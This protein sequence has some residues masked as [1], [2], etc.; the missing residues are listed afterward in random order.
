MKIA[1]LGYGTIGSGV[2]EVLK[3]N[4]DVV[5]MNAGE[6]VEVKYVLDLRDFPGDPVENI[7]THDYE[8]IQ[9][10]EEV[11]LIVETMGGVHPAYEFVKA[12]LEKGRSVCSSNKEL[13]AVYGAE[14]IQIAKAH[15]TNFFF[16]ASVGGGIPI[17]RP[18][19][20]CITA[21]KIERINGILNGTT[22]FILTKMAEDGED[23]DVAL[24]TAQDLG[25][26]EK[27]P[28]ADVEGYDACRKIAI[29]ASLACKKQVNYEDIYTEGITKITATDFLYAK[30]MG[31]AIKIFGTAVMK[32]GKVYAMVAPQ[33]IS[34]A[35]SLFS[36]NGVFNGISVTG[37]MLGDVM[38]YGA[39]AGKL[40]TAS[41]VVSDVV[42][43][44]SKKNTHV[45]VA[46]DSAPLTLSSMDEMENRFFFRVG[47]EEKDQAVK[48]FESAEVIDAGVTGEKGILTGPVKE[49]DAKE[50]FEKL[51]SLRGRIRVQD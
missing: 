43:A 48:M 47:D 29:L 31:F 33:M 27:D 46:W 28:T 15:N 16:E 50:N 44:V 23:F 6:K 40:P 17:I 1:I 11:G 32:D 7:L 35:N 24:K 51:S 49:K 10:D 9:N 30:K 8:E 4:S 41:A 22:N 12:A 42:E 5:A 21:D 37:N 14:L 3:N 45:S 13:V 25:Y 36:V 34:T 26:A 18:L 38:F 39:G 19:I 20:Q 2:A